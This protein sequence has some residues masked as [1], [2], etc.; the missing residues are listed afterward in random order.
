VPLGDRKAL[1]HYRSRLLRRAEA[2]QRHLDGVTRAAHEELVSINDQLRA[3]DSIREP[4]EEDNE[5]SQYR[6]P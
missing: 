6:R 1:D 4:L 2:I 5:S 3:L